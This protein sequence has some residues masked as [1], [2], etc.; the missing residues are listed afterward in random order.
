MDINSFNVDYFSKY[1]NYLI[2]SKG[3]IYKFLN[4]YNQ[5]TSI[6]LENLIKCLD[7]GFFKNLN[8][9]PQNIKIL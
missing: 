2:A 9:L 1:V 4:K 8:D 6:N 7:P 3:P 5:V